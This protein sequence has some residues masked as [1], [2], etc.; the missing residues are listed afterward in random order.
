[1]GIYEKAYTKNHKGELNG[2]WVDLSG[3]LKI[4]NGKYRGRTSWKES[5]GCTIEFKY[6]D[7]HDKIKV[8]GYDS[9]S[10]KV[11]VQYKD[12]D[13]F[14]ISSGHLQ[15]CKLGKMLGIHTDEFK[16]YI[17]EVIDTHN[18]DLIII[19]MEY[20][21]DKSGQN[22]KYYKYTC[23]NCGW[24]EGWVVESGLKK[25]QGCGC[26]SCSN[27]KAVLGINTIW[28]K[29]RF[30]KDL[31]VSEEDAKKYTKR[32]G[33]TI[34]VI[35]PDC[36][37]VKNININT[38]YNKKTISCPCSDKVPYPEKFTF[39]ILNQLNIDFQSQLT[40]STFEWC[41][42][43]KYDFHF[44]YNNNQFII[45][46]HGLQHYKDSSGIY[47]KTL[48]EQQENDKNKYDLAIDNGI[49]PENY[50]VV[51]CRKSELEFI[52]N[53]VLNSRLNE[54]FDL[55]E[56]DWLKC[57]EF[58][59]K[60]LVKKVCD[61]WNQ[62]EEWETA[63]DLEKVFNI[64]SATISKYLKQGTKQKWCS[65]NPK[66]ESFKGSSKSGKRNGKR[67]AIFLNG[68]SKGV[69]DS[70]HELERQSLEIFGVKL[71]TG[72]IS[73]VCIGKQ[74]YHKGYTFKYI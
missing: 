32:S 3:L 20:R 43:Y 67:V 65:Y 63:K 18:R 73:A 15:N 59:L 37:S 61:Y 42:K 1:M 58:A 26:C 71:N 69:F 36:E 74:K 40:K 34:S 19:D 27:K 7:V 21:K 25:G 14:E 35:C 48:L 33:K 55:G 24:D 72:N 23:N 51:D 17:G 66:E 53:N 44:K 4:E 12:N 22:C 49:K 47:K 56:I 13:I 28:D 6:N 11:S 30:M 10:Q 64:S 46:S 16:H 62:K 31:G 68:E 2:N 52:K 38:I 9:K 8:V 41:E 45:E 54:L 60:N 39:A 50:I 57:E 70:C 5:I 29:A